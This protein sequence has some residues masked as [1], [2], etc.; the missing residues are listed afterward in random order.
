HAALAQDDLVVAFAH[1]VF[2]GHQKFFQRGRH[3]ALEQHR[4]FGSSGALEER[5]I[6]HVA[7][8][9]LDNVGVA[10][11]QVQGF[12]V[13]GFSNDAQA[14]AVANFRQDAEAVLAHALEGIGRGAGLVGATAEELGAGGVH[15]LGHG[16][17][18]LAVFHRAR[19]GD[20]GQGASAD[21]GIGA[22]E[23]DDRVF[24]FNIAADQLV[25]L[26]DPNNFLDARHF[27][28]RA[29]FDLGLIAGDANGG[30]LRA[31]DG[32]GAIAHGLDFLTRLPDLL[33]GGVRLHYNQHG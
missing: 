19:T 28:Q 32:V 8:A 5:E 25:G 10:L 9:D 26:A 18:L 2:R 24:F 12:V 30:A 15:A 16:E 20:D 6:L 17:S 14:E 29:R 3:A 27:L 31:R 33:L 7:G 1:D 21:G 22:G 23:G 13:H 4:F 11:H